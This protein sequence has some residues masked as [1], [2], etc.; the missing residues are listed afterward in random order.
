MLFGRVSGF[1]FSLAL[2]NLNGC[3]IEGLYLNNEQ[4]CSSTE[5]LAVSPD[6]EVSF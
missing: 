3:E 4:F 5:L 2:K 1:A 6:F